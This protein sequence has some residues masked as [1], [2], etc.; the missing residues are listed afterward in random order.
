M[1]TFDDPLC[2]RCGESMH[3]GEEKHMFEECIYLPCQDV[4]CRALR[5]PRTFDQMSDAQMHLRCHKVPVRHT[6]PTPAL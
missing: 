3:N 6:A 2:P 4:S 1:P 5:N